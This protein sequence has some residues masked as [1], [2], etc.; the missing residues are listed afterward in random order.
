MVRGWKLTNLANYDKVQVQA[1]SSIDCQKKCT[2][3]SCD[4]F[5]YNENT[6]DCTEIYLLGDVYYINVSDIHRG[7]EKDFLGMSEKSIYS[8]C[9]FIYIYIYI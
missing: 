6:K 3:A 4:Y 9:R 8:F 5:Y 1:N 7:T 2:K